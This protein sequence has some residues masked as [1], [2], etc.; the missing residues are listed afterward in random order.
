MGIAGITAKKFYS[1]A[2]NWHLRGVPI[3]IY[4]EFT[5]QKT[6]FFLWFPIFVAFGI[7]L[8][9]S[10]S[11]EPPLIF[12]IFAVLCSGMWLFVSWISKFRVPAIL[13]TLIA[14]GFLSAQIRTHIVHTPI[15]QKTLGPVS[16]SGII[17]AIE[18]LGDKS[19]ARLILSNLDI[20][21]LSIRDTPNKIRLKIWKD[22]GLVVGQRVKVLA[23][24]KKPSAPVIPEG[25]D[26]QR[27]LY[28]KQIG[29]VGFG[30]NK[31]EIIQDVSPYSFVRIVERMRQV[32]AASVEKNM[33]YPQA[34]L[35]MALI[36]GRK[37]AI[38]K[39][40]KEAM[41]HAGL[42][43]MLAISGMHVGLFSGVLFFFSRLLM[44]LIPNFALKHPIKK[45]AAI[46][47]MFGAIAYMFLAGST[48][49]TQRAILMV[50]I[51]FLAIILDRSPLSLRSVAFAALVV[52]L[53]FPESLLSA[54]FHMSFAAVT[55]LILFYEWIRPLWSIWSG[56]S[57]FIKRSVLYFAGICITTIIATFAT[58]P[59]ALFH[60]QQLAVYSLIANVI[61][62]PLLAFIVMPFVVLA[63]FLMPFGFE[64]LA[65]FPLGIGIHGILETAHFVSELPNAVLK[66]PA[67]PLAGLVNL[68]LGML[69]FTLWQGRL[70]YVSLICFICF[71]SSIFLYKQP[72]ILISSSYNLVAFK[73]KGQG[74]YI[75][76]KRR[77]KFVSENWARYYGNSIDEAIVWP[78]EGL[79][80]FIT[81]GEHGCRFKINGYNISYIEHQM[82]G[83]EEC[84][85]ADILLSKEPLKGCKLSKVIDFFDTYRNGAHAIWLG[86]SGEDNALLIKTTEEM[87]GM[88]PW[89][90]LNEHF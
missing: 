49:P 32:V 74:F 50:S 62:M 51:V 85:N 83:Q 30:F 39:K 37:T 9:F 35:A 36:T 33:D 46:F 29:A 6:S 77:E 64:S 1:K 42:A 81:C 38:D 86:N 16:I 67:W 78:K 18:D 87:R 21:R 8:Y 76:N 25:F 44:S 82:V 13:L 45:Y 7:G 65:F 12:G 14:V 31:P 41:R 47:A 40:D 11:V 80:S 89:S 27:Y 75:S 19:G 22:Q 61:A 58:A 17:D 34:S 3:A 23:K 59:F 26:F 53:F 90:G 28:F 5:H 55:G 72:D 84:A 71:L 15:L 69:I 54:S 43:H 48:I 60:F 70:R 56:Q 24:I 2:F 4:T 73:I 66:A 57:G 68:V 88:R 20:E 52:L 79:K 63:L 10:L